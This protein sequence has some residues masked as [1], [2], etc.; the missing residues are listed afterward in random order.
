MQEEMSVQMCGRRRC[1]NCKANRKG[2]GFME[3]G[4]CFVRL[5]VGTR[6]RAFDLTARILRV[7][8]KACDL[9]TSHN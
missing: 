1:D 6:R 7:L 5:R 9:F 8:L 3:I 2:V 4:L